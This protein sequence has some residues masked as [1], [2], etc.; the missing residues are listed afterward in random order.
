MVQR[1]PMTPEGYGVL[2]EELKRLKSTERPK[3][4]QDI[5]DARALGD[6]SENAE[7]HAAKERQAFLEGRMREVEDKL[8]RAEIIDNTGYS[9]ERVM[10]GATVTLTDLNTDEEITYRIVGDHEADPRNGKIS[11]NSPIARGVIGRNLADEVEIRTPKGV[12]NFE[13][14]AVDYK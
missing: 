14:A 1:V 9:G 3:N 11:V 2:N 12:R 4:I 6:L 7:Y 8:G 5:E 13:I 10:F